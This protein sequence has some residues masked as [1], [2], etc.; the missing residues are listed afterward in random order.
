M[1]TNF[2]SRIQ[3][4]FNWLDNNNLTANS[5]EFWY[6][7]SQQFMEDRPLSL[8]SSTEIS[9][10]KQ[11]QITNEQWKKQR[12]AKEEDFN[13]LLDGKQEATIEFLLDKNSKYVFKDRV[14]ADAIAFYKPFH[15][16][17]I[18]EWGIYFNL[19]KF[20]E[21]L[22]Y[23]YTSVCKT[24]KTL[25]KGV[26]ATLAMFEIFHH[27]HYHHL[28][29]ST[30]FTMETIL[31]SISR[32]M[33]RPLYIEY[34]KMMYTKSYNENCSYMKDMPLEEAL[35]NAYAYNSLG[36]AQSTQMLYDRMEINKYKNAVKN[37]W[38]DDPPGY[39]SAG[40]YIGSDT[41]IGNTLLLHMMFGTWD[42]QDDI[43]LMQV[44]SRVMPSGYT[45]LF[46]KPDIPV[47]FIGKEKEYNMLLDILPNPRAA[48][49]YLEFPYTTKKFSAKILEEKEKRKIKSSGSQ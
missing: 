25:N 47:Y 46:A 43:A 42:F 9:K 3:S 22:E 16:A 6:S 7:G 32:E 18:E 8:L 45:S 12:E 19:S 37:S 38:M 13:K 10:Y 35:A 17:P 30:A 5:Y 20:L 14:P 2:V 23:I 11:P 24:Y 49:A 36:F 44:A 26:I 31:A 28:V 39:R 21:Y 27:E 33:L 1:V 34:S 15:F 41:Y 40:N 48:Y 4:I 29:E